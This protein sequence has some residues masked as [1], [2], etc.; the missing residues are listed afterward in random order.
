MKYII[1][2]LK[3][4]A[5]AIFLLS[6]LASCGNRAAEESPAEREATPTPLPAPLHSPATPEPVYTLPAASELSTHIFDNTHI[7]DDCTSN[8]ETAI[9]LTCASTLITM[10]GEI[11]D[12]DDGAMWGTHL[13]K[14]FMFACPVT[15]F[16]VA[17][18]QDL[19]NHL[20][21]QADSV[22]VGILPEAVWIGNTVTEA[23]GELWG[24]VTVSYAQSIM[25]DVNR[26]VGIMIHELFHAWQPELFAGERYTGSFFIPIAE[27]D[28][29]VQIMVEITALLH[30]LA[31]YGEE[32]I[33][34]IHV[35]L[36][37]REARRQQNPGVSYREN[38]GEIHEGTAVYTELRFVTEDF[39]E[40]VR[41]LN[42]YVDTHFRDS[43]LFIFGYATGALYGLLLDALD[44]NWRIGLNWNT[45]LGALL[46]EAAGMHTL[47]PFDEIDMS[48]F[49]YD[50]IRATEIAWVARYE[51]HLADAKRIFAQPTLFVPRGGEL[52]LNYDNINLLF[53]PAR[54][55]GMNYVVY[56]GDLIFEH[57]FGRIVISNGHM[58]LHRAH[59]IS[60]DGSNV[61]FFNEITAYDMIFDEYGASTAYW[62]LQLNPGYRIV[63]RDGNYQIRGA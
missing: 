27:I 18:Q 62:T 23:F 57:A 8:H 25:P 41:W 61:T 6:F 34:A 52:S 9:C 10:M 50:E 47:T 49:G 31:S 54:Q 4:V 21:R 63:R 16:A 43:S 26:V 32:R 53:L 59:V 58:M 45:D 36:S 22:Y 24:M 37:A 55:Q 30:A 1:G 48:P 38:S 51:R 2:A 12:R 44:V 7:F 5:L 13:R 56:F 42:N 28:A 11:F 60:S 19:H 29:R 15:R 39:T 46:R 35:A 3:Q 20:E 14:P 17:S 40:Q 33:Q